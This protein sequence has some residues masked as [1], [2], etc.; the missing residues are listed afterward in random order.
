MYDMTTV[1]I[2]TAIAF[3]FLLWSIADDIRKHSGNE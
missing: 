3:A 2:I 1:I